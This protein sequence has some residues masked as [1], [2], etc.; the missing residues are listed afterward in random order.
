MQRT[1]VGRMLK[2]L[3]TYQRRFRQIKRTVLCF[4][5]ALHV[6]PCTAAAHNGNVQF[7]QNAVYIFSFFHKV[8]TAQRRMALSHRV[9]RPFQPIGIKFAFDLYGKKIDIIGNGFRIHALLHDHLPLSKGQRPRIAFFR[10]GQ[11]GFHP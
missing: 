3:A 6:S 11:A 4:H 10:F 2:H 1:Q 8:D 7:I 5:D 9:E